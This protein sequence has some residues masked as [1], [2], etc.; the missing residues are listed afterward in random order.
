MNSQSDA[1]Y[2]GVDDLENEE[3]EEYRKAEG[4]GPRKTTD[5]DAS[6]DSE[7]QGFSEEE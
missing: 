5:S 6:S 1:D 7:G 3:Y 2:D 4:K